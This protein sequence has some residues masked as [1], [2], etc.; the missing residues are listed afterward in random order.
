MATGPITVPR[1]AIT[2]P[3]V[4]DT[5]KSQKRRA[6]LGDYNP[7]MI[8]NELDYIHERL[9]G[10]VT[11]T[12]GIVNLSSGATLGEVITQLNLITDTLR[13]AGLLQRE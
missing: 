6:I 12:A 11:E 1:Q 8:N 10:I 2:Q 13:S 3:T 9:N 5:R 7:Q 4:A